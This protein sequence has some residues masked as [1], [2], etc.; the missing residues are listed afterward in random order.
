M[1]DTAA[2]YDL[3]VPDLIAAL[4]R[5]ATASGRTVEGITLL[6]GEPTEQADGAAELFERLQG[7]G[8]S[9]M[10]YSGYTIEA[11]RRRGPVMARLLAATD[12]LVDGPFLPER[13][14]EDLAWRGSENQRIHCLT[15]RYSAAALDAAFFEQGKGFSLDFRADGSVAASGLQRRD[16]AAEME[17][18]LAADTRSVVGKSTPVG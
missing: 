4:L 2:G 9:T 3:A 15:K 6:G 11:L 8:W 1:L 10:L 17:R 12:L 18:K 7:E 13:Y 14:R 5:A 16:A